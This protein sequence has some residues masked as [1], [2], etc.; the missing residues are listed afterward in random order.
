[1]ALRTSFNPHPT[2]ELQ[3]VT[4]D[5]GGRR[6]GEINDSFDAAEVIG[7]AAQGFSAGEFSALLEAMRAGL[8]YANVHSMAIPGGEIRGQLKPRGGGGDDDD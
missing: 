2:P 4:P 1:V 7:P 5:C 3:P 6:S 8:T